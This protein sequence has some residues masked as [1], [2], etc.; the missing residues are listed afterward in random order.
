MVDQCYTRPDLLAERDW[1]WDH[2]HN[3]GPQ[4]AA[5]IS[6]GFRHTSGE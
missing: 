4:T 2:H 6:N 3:P 1:L 5:M